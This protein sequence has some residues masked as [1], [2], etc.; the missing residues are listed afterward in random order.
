MP[1]HGGSGLNGRR[2]TVREAQA[3]LRAL[4]EATD[5]CRECPIGQYATQS[6]FGEALCARY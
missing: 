4:D 3:A 6:V 2:I 1:D 5:A